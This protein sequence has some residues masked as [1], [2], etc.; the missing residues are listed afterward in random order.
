MHYIGGYLYIN[1]GY[2]HSLKHLAITSFFR[3]YSQLF[4]YKEL[5]KRA[6]GSGRDRLFFFD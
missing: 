5:T 1:K 2:I 6:G 4:W 3:C